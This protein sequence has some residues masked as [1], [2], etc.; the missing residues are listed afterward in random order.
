[1]GPFCQC[2]VGWIGQRCQYMDVGV[3][4]HA[5]YV[6]EH[7]RDSSKMVARVVGLSFAGLVLLAALT[8]LGFVYYRRQK[9]KGIG[10]PRRLAKVSRAIY[11]MRQKLF[12]RQTDKDATCNFIESDDLQL[13]LQQQQQIVENGNLCTVCQQKVQ[14]PLWKNRSTTTVSADPW[15]QVNLGSPVPNAMFQS[16]TA[17][18]WTP[19]ALKSMSFSECRL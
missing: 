15:S 3:E 12:F 18:R 13:Q 1:M 19:S 9:E 11:D 6:S 4:P 14:V 10:R 2:P 17:D 16:A 5:P 7:G 8:V